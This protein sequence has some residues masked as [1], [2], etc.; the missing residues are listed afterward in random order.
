M[1]DSV[2][3]SV[4]RCPALSPSPYPYRSRSCGGGV[5]YQFVA[6][7]SHLTIDNTSLSR[8]S[9][10]RRG[11]VLKGTGLMH[12]TLSLLFPS[13]GCPYS[14][15]KD[16][17]QKGSIKRFAPDRRTPRSSLCRFTYIVF[18]YFAHVD[19]KLLHEFTN[20]WYVIR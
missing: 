3:R 16:A 4:E 11:G 7:H 5:G 17:I 9:L 8:R 20:L 18:V 10:W 15:D 13:P 2:T 19:R 1:E 14:I 6:C 12:Q